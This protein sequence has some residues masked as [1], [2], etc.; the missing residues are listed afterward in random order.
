MVYKAN[1]KGIVLKH[2]LL[3]VRF[4]FYALAD[5]IGYF[6]WDFLNALHV[7]YYAAY[8]VIYKRQSENR[9]LRSCVCAMLPPIFQR[10]ARG[11]DVLT[12][13][14]ALNIIQYRHYMMIFNDNQSAFKTQYNT[15]VI[16]VSETQLLWYFI[17]AWFFHI[18]FPLPFV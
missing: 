18:N 14:E 17:R 9:S 7:C 12:T 2:S 16:W 3:R 1:V 8:E 11:R 6:Q 5:F 4:K 10:C 15:F 13:S